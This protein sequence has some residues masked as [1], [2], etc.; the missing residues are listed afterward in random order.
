MVALDSYTERSVSGTGYHVV[1]RANLNGR[2][3]HPE[4][5]GVFQDDRFFYF[6]R[7]A[8]P[9]TPTTIEERQAE[10]DAGARPLPAEAAGDVNALHIRTRQ[11]VDLD[12]R[13]LIEKAMAAKNGADFARLWNGDSQ[14]YASQSEADLALCNMLAFWTGRDADRI[15]QHV[16][17]ERAHAREVGSATDYREADDRDRDRGDEGRL[18][19]RLRKVRP[20]GD[21]PGRT[22]KVLARRRTVEGAGASLRPHVRGRRTGRTFLR[23]PD[24]S[25]EA[26]RPAEDVPRDPLLTRGGGGGVRGRRGGLRRA[27]ARRRG[28]TPCSPPA[29]RPVWYGDGGA[30]KTT[31]GLDRAFHLVRRAATGSGCPCRS[32]CGCSGSRTRGRGGSSARRCGA[33][34]EAWDGPPLEGRLHVLVTPWA[35]FT[36]ANER[37]R[38]ELVELVRELEIDVVIAGPVARLGAEG[39]GTPEEIQAFV[40]LLELVRADLDRPLAYELIH[41]ENKAGDVSGAWE[42]AT[43][44]LVHVQARGNGHTAIVWGRRAGRPTSTG[45]TWKLELAA[46][47]SG[48]RSTRRRRRPTRR[49][50]TKLLEL[51]AGR[52]GRVVERLRRAADRQGEAEAVGSRPAARGR[53]ARERGHGEGDAAVPAR[54]GGRACADNT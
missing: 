22:P 53:A 38:A 9:G 39:G 19:P 35:R 41:H 34:L 4:G 21:A 12:D 24:V 26:R 20:S 54:A 30:G 14:G 37:M 3:R 48:S 46:T 7:R 28:R 18:Q 11:P 31:L 23:A 36:F 17:L 42:G 33:K 32:R 50:R 47:A 51:V 25:A 45:K 16:P 49:S 43:D 1:V 44:T 2:G 6:T 27:A 13:E 52:T 40:D 8:R 5:I 15:D 29:G 10:L